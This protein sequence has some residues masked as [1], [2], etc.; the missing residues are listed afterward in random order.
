MFP[1]SCLCSADSK[2]NSS[3][4]FPWIT[5]TRVSSRWRASISMRIVINITPHAQRGRQAWAGA[6]ARALVF[7][8]R[9]G[10][11]A[12]RD[13]PGCKENGRLCCERQAGSEDRPAAPRVHAAALQGACVGGGEMPHAASTSLA[14]EKAGFNGGP[15]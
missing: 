13:G 12:P 7:G 6:A 4:L 15:S 9:R 5:A 10:G 8:R 2:S 1:L 11:D 3:I 14:G